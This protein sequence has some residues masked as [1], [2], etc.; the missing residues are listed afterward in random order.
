MTPAS[1]VSFATVFATTLLASCKSVISK[2]KD[3]SLSI[4]TESAAQSSTNAVREISF[5][6]THTSASLQFK[7]L[8][9]FQR[10]ESF[11]APDS[12]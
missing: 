11:L 7:T 1:H 5:E 10:M 6:D 2:L 3:A 9:V 12:A 8:F 4:K